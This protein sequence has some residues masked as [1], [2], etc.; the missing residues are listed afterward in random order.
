VLVTGCDTGFGLRLA[1]HLE[2]LGFTVFAGCLLA[3]RRGA[4]AEE[5]RGLDRPRLHVL[6][7]DVTSAKEWEAARRSVAVMTDESPR[8]AGS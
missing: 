6:Q 3:D 2:S 8:A 1:Q 5:L 7:L 4:G